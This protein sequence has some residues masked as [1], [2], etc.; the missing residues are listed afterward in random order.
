M[1][2]LSQQLNLFLLALS[3][4]SRLPVANF[5]QYS[6]DNLN[7]A[8]RYFGLVGW[9]LGAMVALSILLLAP[10]LPLAVVIFLAMV[11]SLMLTGAFHED[12]L[13]DMADGFGGGFTAARKL[14]IMK[15]SRLGTYGTCALLAALEGKF[16]LLLHIPQILIAV[17]VAYPLS[18]VVAAGFIFDMPYVSDSDQSKSKPLATRQS[19]TDLSILLATGFVSLLLLPLYL[20]VAIV[21]VLVVFRF[22]FK[23][24]LIRQIGGFTGDCLGAAQQLSE[25]LI[26]LTMV[27]MWSN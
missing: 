7:R 23:R 9:L 10:F 8:N 20:A 25:L 21:A 17:L 24:F 13:A 18:R 11:F 14:E 22:L 15:D 2:V 27:A 1:K 4:F 3:F 6:E 19:V 16:L 5:T 26:Y 12:G